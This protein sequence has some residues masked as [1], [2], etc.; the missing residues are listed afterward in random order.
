MKFIFIFIINQYIKASPK[1]FRGQ[2]V[3]SPSCSFYSLECFKRFGTLGGIYLTISRIKRC[4]P[5]NTGE[6]LVPQKIK[7][8]P[9]ILKYI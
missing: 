7:F 4:T 9:C 2:C 1:R 6:D 3:F 8:Y 5:I